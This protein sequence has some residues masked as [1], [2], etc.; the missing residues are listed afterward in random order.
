MYSLR[1]ICWSTL[2]VL[3]SCT[4]SSA[5]VLLLLMLLL[6]PA[7]ACCCLLRAHLGVVGDL[8]HQLIVKVAGVGVQDAQPA[9]ARQL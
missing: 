7:A 1:Q 6:L 8:R 2:L 4:A 5:T 9:Q 3:A